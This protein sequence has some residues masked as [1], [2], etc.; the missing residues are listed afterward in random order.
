MRGAGPVPS[1]PIRARQR[2]RGTGAR[3]RRQTTLLPPSAAERRSRIPLPQQPVTAAKR[4]PV[5]PPAERNQWEAQLLQRLSQ[6]ASKPIEKKEERSPLAPARDLRPPW[7]FRP[8]GAFGPRSWRC[9][10][11]R[12]LPS[13]ARAPPGRSCHDP[14]ARRGA[15]VSGPSLRHVPPPCF[16]G[17]RG[18]RGGPELQ[19]PAGRGRGAVAGRPAR[20]A[21]RPGLWRLPGAVSGLGSAGVTGGIPGSRPGVP[22]PA[23][24]P[25]RNRHVVLLLAGRGV[26]QRPGA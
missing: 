8:C 20:L 21:G 22:D 24:P 3:P 18:Q 14:P 17:G 23:G 19:V 12:P 6:S 25:R 7:A 2:G 5:P 1:A 15:A 11:G 13:V 9:C 16:A 4:M 26:W 10:R